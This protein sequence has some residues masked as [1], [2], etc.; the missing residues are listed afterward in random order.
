MK[1]SCTVILVGALLLSGQVVAENG[2]EMYKSTISGDSSA[3]AFTVVLLPDTQYYSKDH[4]D[5]YRAQTKLIAWSKEC[6]EPIREMYNIKPPKMVIHLGDITHDNTDEEWDRADSA[7]AVLDEAHIP[8]TV[9]PGNHDGPVRFNR[10]FGPRRFEGQKW[11]KDWYRGHFPCTDK[12]ILSPHDCC[13]NDNNYAYFEQGGLEF[14]VVNLEYAPR[15][16]VLCWADAVIRR[17][18][19]RRVIIVTHGY[20]THDADFFKDG[21]WSAE[22]TVW[23]ELA[24]RHSSVFLVLCGHKNDSEYVRQEGATREGGVKNTVDAILTDYQWEPDKDHPNGGWMRTLRF[25]PCMN[26]IYVRTF[27]VLD[28]VDWFYD[29][30][31]P[32]DPAHL[33]HRYPLDYNMTTPIPYEYYAYGVTW[34]PNLDPNLEFA[35]TMRVEQGKTFEILPGKTLI[36]RDGARMVVDGTVI[37]YGTDNDPIWFVSGQQRPRAKISSKLTITG[38]GGTIRIR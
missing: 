32:A 25:V 2:A 10:Y 5:T 34:D 33:C 37:A 21:E 20:L 13:K 15:T 8:Y 30:N 12:Y 31:Y 14:M 36:F 35:G 6:N 19:T 23:L 18:P 4:A 11:C 26:K 9:I 38:G 1:I 27:S 29:P 16:K 17:H 28:G 24:R 7:H 22:T 3:D